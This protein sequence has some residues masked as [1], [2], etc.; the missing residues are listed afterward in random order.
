M[1]CTEPKKI[2]C[3]FYSESCHLPCATTWTGAVYGTGEVQKTCEAVEA[4]EE[5]SRENE[6]H[7]TDMKVLSTTSSVRLVEFIGEIPSKRA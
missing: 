3:E 6:V 4:V 2:I 5:G 1:G 7:E